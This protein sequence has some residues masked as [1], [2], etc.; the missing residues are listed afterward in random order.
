MPENFVVTPWKVEGTVDYERLIKEFGTQPLTEDLIKRIEKKAGF[1]HLFLRRKVFF[2]HR[3]LDFVLNKYDKG[4]KFALYTGRK[5]SGN[6]HL[7]HLVPWI[8]TKHLQDAFDVELYFQLTDDEHFYYTRDATLEDGNKLAYENA[9]D[10]IALGFKPKKTF[11][12]TDTEYANVMYPIAAKIAKHTTLSTVKAVFG[13]DDS[14][15]VGL[16]FYPALQAATCF[17][18]SVLKGKNVP[19]LIPAAIDQDPYWRGIARSVAEK[20]GFYKPAQIH[21]RF[22]P[23]LGEG[24][25]MSASQPDTAIFTT[26]NEEEIKRKIYK[27]FTG[28]QATAAEQRQKGANVDVCTVCKYFSFLF[29]ED[30]AELH[31]L[32]E[33]ERSGKTLCGDLK[34]LL[35]ERVTKFLKKH[36]TAR[37]QAKGKL[38][39]FFL[40]G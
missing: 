5:P 14:T 8:F 4:E 22:L 37:K 10:I 18:P 28:G 16:H 25:K 38:K 29:E 35:T 30:D 39:K 36:Q 33:K 19:V 24:G 15:N 3:D 21:C 27:A 31:D 32:L 11:L 7:G 26:D 17:L 9:L 23:G 13:F 2:S 1:R 12:F 20:L 6:T 34:A 40:K